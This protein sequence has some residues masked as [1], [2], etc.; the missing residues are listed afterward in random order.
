[1]LRGRRRRALAGSSFKSG[2]IGALRIALTHS[3]DL[4]LLIPLLDQIK[5]L[6]QPAGIQISARR[7]REVGEYLKKGEAELG[8]AAEIDE[9]WDRLDTWP[10]FTE[11]FSS[12]SRATA[13]RQIRLR[14]SATERC[15]RGTIANTPT[16]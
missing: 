3:I 7:G 1:M 8:I 11:D 5:R 2:E 9:D 6:V 13:G 4:S 15:C 12:S 16:G 14:G 10:L